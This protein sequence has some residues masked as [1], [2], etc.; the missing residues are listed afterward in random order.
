MNSTLHNLVHAPS[1][2]IEIESLNLLVSWSVAF[3]RGSYYPGITGDA[4]VV[5][6]SPYLPCHDRSLA[7]LGLHLPSKDKQLLMQYGYNEAWVASMQIAAFLIDMSERRLNVALVAR[8][9]I[10]LS[11]R[12]YTQLL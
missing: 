5:S 2:T 9:G 12:I 4:V 7:S 3:I 1:L 11:R 10:E 6:G 8:S